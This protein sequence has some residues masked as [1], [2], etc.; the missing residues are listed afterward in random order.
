M[1]SK[2][3]HVRKGWTDD[4]LQWKR[5]YKDIYKYSWAGI[6]FQRNK[7]NEIPYKKP[8][9]YIVEAGM[10]KGY[11]FRQFEEHREIVCKNRLP[12]EKL[13]SVVYVGQSNDLRKRFKNYVS[14][15][16]NRFKKYFQGLNNLQFFWTYHKDFKEQVRRD[17]IED[18]LIEVFGPTLNKKR[19]INKK[20]RAIIDIASS[21]LHRED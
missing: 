6:E 3:D 8:G 9:I 21:G 20:T 5:F 13:K 11:F 10:P 15:A 7:A 12:F 14:G 19:E 18:L 1:D 17:Y 16:D 2:N 4:I